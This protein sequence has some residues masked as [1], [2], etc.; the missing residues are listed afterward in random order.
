MYNPGSPMCENMIE[1][2]F[3]IAVADKN[4]SE[5]RTIN[6]TVPDDFEVKDKGQQK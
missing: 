3:D 1:A 2:R 6:I 4:N 5:I